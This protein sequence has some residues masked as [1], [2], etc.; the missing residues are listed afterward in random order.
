M[1]Q[2][3]VVLVEPL[4]YGSAEAT[5]VTVLVPV[6]VL[7]CMLVH[8]VSPLAAIANRAIPVSIVT[9]AQAPRVNLRRT[10]NKSNPVKPPTHH[11]IEL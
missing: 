2:A 1:P 9:V 8:A 7:Y 4:A 11:S 10:Q 6:G 5:T 3:A